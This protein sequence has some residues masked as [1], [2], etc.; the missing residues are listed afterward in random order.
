[1]TKIAV[2]QVREEELPI[3]EK[4]SKDN[5]VEVKIIDGQ[6]TPENV[7]LA[8]GFDGVTTSQNM[9]VPTEVYKKL[10]EYGIKQIAQR[11]AGFDYY[12]LEE[13]TK[14]DIIISNVPV[15]SPESIAEFVLTQALMLIRKVRTIEEKTNEGDFRW[16]P[17][18]RGGLLGEMTVGVIGTGHIGRIAARLFKSFGA[19][20][21]GYDLY[22]N[23]EATKYLEY[24]DTVEELVKEA[25]IVTLHVPATAD[26]FHQFNYEMFKLFKP[27]AYFIND[28]R[29]SVVDT[30][31]LIKSLD[32]GLIAGAALDTYENEGS[33]IPVDNRE[34][35]IDDGLLQRLLAHPKILFT[36]HIAHY[37]NVSVR[38][39]MNIGLDSTLEVIET[40]DT[41]NRVN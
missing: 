1:M 12:D 40:G 11:S 27:T 25:D 26:N 36:P 21:I 6:L 29:G 8:K 41:K 17:A 7:H 5:N 10:H 31:E 28:A 3:V 9:K 35:G 22:P 15:Y 18:I 30:E 32:D 39:I 38:N 2:Y 33:Y 37:T 14:N 4:W 19:N 24:K 23:E 20:V 16:Q 34:T 13:A